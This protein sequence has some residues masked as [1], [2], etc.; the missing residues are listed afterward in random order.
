MDCHAF[1]VTLEVA[2]K[3]LSMPWLLG[4]GFSVPLLHTH[5]PDQHHL[6]PLHMFRD[7]SQCRR[8]CMPLDHELACA[9]VVASHAHR[10]HIP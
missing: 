5:L 4:V 8:T 6:E 7:L 2:R 9:H 1:L 10:R 3:M